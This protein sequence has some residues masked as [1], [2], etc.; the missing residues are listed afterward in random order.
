MEQDVQED[1]SEEELDNDQRLTETSGETSICVSR[2]IVSDGEWHIIKGIREGYK[3]T[4]EVDE[5]SSWKRNTSTEYFLNSLEDLLQEK[6]MRDKIGHEE[7]T[8]KGRVT[9]IVGGASNLF[10]GEWKRKPQ[11]ESDGSVCVDDIRISGHPLPLPPGINGSRWGQVTSMSG[12]E[13]GCTSPKFCP[14][15]FCMS[16]QVCKEDFWKASCSCPSN[17]YLSPSG[18]CLELQQCLY[19]PCL[20]GGTCIPP[21]AG[22]PSPYLCSCLKGYSGKNCEWSAIEGQRVSITG[23]YVFIASSLS[24]LLFVLTIFSLLYKIY[25]RKKNS[26]VSEKDEKR[27][28]RKKKNKWKRREKPEEEEE[29]ESLKKSLK[30]KGSVEMN[31]FN[32]RSGK[33]HRD[34]SAPLE[35]PVGL[36]SDC[37][38]A[39]NKNFF[40]PNEGNKTHFQKISPNIKESEISRILSGL[41]QDAAEG[42]VIV[43]QD[44][45]RAY[46]YEGDESSSGSLRSAISGLRHEY[47]FELNIKPLIPE[48]GEA[49]DLLKHFPDAERSKFLNY[50]IDDSPSNHNILK[51]EC[52]RNELS[53]HCIR[54]KNHEESSTYDQ[55]QST[56]IEPS[57]YYIQ[58]ENEEH[59]S[60]YNQLQGRYPTVQSNECSCCSKERS[61]NFEAISQS[62]DLSE[63]PS[64]VECPCLKDRNSMSTEKDTPISSI[65]KTVS[66][67]TRVDSGMLLSYLPSSIPTTKI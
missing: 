39:E 22:T 50:S 5:G 12:I 24:F 47:S 54:E 56:S 11:N 64:L 42:V 57:P 67:K 34:S 46:A 18:E 25:K 8:L 36:I 14:S 61:G 49:I 1:E 9:A 32:E 21:G 10:R 6:R 45:L 17:H 40:K 58:N 3:L 60:V 48:V 65:S 19:K 41:E 63:V 2:V 16:P 55:I 27:L 33:L 4:L 30:N 20:N 28:G 23:Y 35:A 66:L 43:P 62:A 26:K 7:T 59:C 38:A 37:N 29:E 44:D 15:H 53:S 31:Y 52:T 13:T 51:N